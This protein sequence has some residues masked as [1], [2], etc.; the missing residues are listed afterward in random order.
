MV[1]VRRATLADTATMTGQ[2][3][4]G[5][6]SGTASMVAS[7]A[8][9]PMHP[10]APA[11]P[12]DR[13]RLPNAA[14]ASRPMTVIRA[15]PSMMGP[16]TGTGQVHA[17]LMISAMPQQPP[18]IGP[19]ARSLRAARLAGLA[20]VKAARTTCGSPNSAIAA[21]GG[22]VGAQALAEVAAVG[23]LKPVGQFLND[24]RGQLGG[25]LRQVAADQAGF[26]PWPGLQGG[27]DR[28]GEVPPVGSLAGQC[29]RPGR[30]QPVLTPLAPGHH[31][32]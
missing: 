22:G 20:P 25:Q 15:T 32:P 19:V 18:T 24:R 30:G 14:A 31:R 6:A 28:G 5:T 26:G 29:P 27:A 16:P 9:M 13:Y 7:S 17:R 21:P 3:T 2:I 12:T 10:A 23:L 11:R 8:A 1:K 4:A